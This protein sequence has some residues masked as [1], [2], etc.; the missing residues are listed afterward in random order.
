MRVSWYS[1]CR[2]IR[3]HNSATLYTYSAGTRFE[4]RSDLQFFLVESFLTLLL[5]LH[6]PALGSS[7]PSSWLQIQRPG[8]DSRRYQIFCKVVGL[9][10]GPLGLM[11]TIE[12][13]LRR[14]RSGCGKEHRDYCLR[15]PPLDTPLSS[16]VRTNVAD[17]RRSLGRYNSLT[18]SGHG[19]CFTVPP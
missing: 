5:F 3:W 15:D 7:G 13:L 2:W 10:R 17:K 1:L 9:E 18:D 19:V 8:F 14:K 11:S 16:K 6:W 12:E 4:S